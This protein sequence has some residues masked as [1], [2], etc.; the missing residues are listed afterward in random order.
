MHVYERRHARNLFAV[1]AQFCAEVTWLC[2]DICLICWRSFVAGCGI[3]HGQEAQAG[4]L[5]NPGRV[6]LVLGSYRLGGGAWPSP[7]ACGSIEP[8]PVAFSRGR[9]AT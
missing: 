7:A 9:F 5:F 4:A 8:G 6:C 2:F 3:A 1:G